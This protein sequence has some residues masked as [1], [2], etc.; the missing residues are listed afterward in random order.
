MAKMDGPKYTGSLIV[1]LTSVK[2]DLIDLAPGAMKG[3]RA[4]QD[5]MAEVKKELAE[6]MPG[7]GEAADI[8]PHVYQRFLDRTAK[9]EKIQEKK[10]EVAKAMEVLNETAVKL[11]NDVEDDISV[12]AK[13]AQSTAARQKNPGLA[14]PFEVT[15]RYNS[16]GAEKALKTRRKN[17]E[18]KADPPEPPP[19]E[20]EPKPPTR[21]E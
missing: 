6:A 7:H 19:A 11:E 1:D 15:I 14:A 5:G 16:Q 10:L 17:A 8:P 20:G 21:S 18:A 9:L 2:D 3:A 12:M 4:E 13:A